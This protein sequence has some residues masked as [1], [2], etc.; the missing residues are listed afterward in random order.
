MPSTPGQ[1]A[2][3]QRVEGLIGLAIPLLDLVLSAG[4]RISRVVGPEDEYYPIR[5]G[6]E[7][8]T[9]P[10]SERGEGETLPPGAPRGT[11]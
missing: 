11:D 6:G 3:Q 8:L 7:A 5:S 1:V 10:R 4:D 9:I 2:L